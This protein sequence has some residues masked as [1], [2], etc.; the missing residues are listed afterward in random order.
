MTRLALVVALVA[1]GG[2]QPPPAQ[3]EPQPQ[4]PTDT[5]SPI[6]KRRDAACDVVAKRTS[7]CAAESEKALLAAGKI[8]QQEYAEATDP[9]VIAKAADMYAEKCK[10][11]DYSSRQIRVLEKCPQYESECTPFFQ[12][13]DNVQPQAK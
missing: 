11:R 5:R 12:C 1:C 8:S 4:G 13:L 6:E 9:R 2:S 10:S 3:P 7:A